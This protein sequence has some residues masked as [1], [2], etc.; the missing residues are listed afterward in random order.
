MAG[1]VTMVLVNVHM[2]TQA[3]LADLVSPLFKEHTY[4]LFSLKMETG[5]MC[6]VS[7]CIIKH[8]LKTP[9]QQSSLKETKRFLMQSGLQWE[10]K[11][12]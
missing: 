4:F 11:F 7:C 9:L 3:Q 1:L 10:R 2:A 8:V 6:F 5:T 12:E